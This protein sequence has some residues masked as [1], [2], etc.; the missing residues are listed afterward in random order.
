MLTA[1]KNKE[2]LKQQAFL[3]GEWCDALSGETTDVLDPASQQIIGSVPSLSPAEVQKA[4]DAAAVAFKDWSARP[5]GERA[6][7][8]KKWHRLIE[9]NKEDLAQILTMEQGKPV[10]EARVEVQASAALIE[11]FSEEAR[12][13]YG[14]IIPSPANGRQTLVTKQPVGVCAA[15]TPWNFPSSMLARKVAP[16]LA[17]GCAIVVKPSEYT[18][19]SALALAALAEQAGLPSGLFNVATGDARMIGEVI[20]ASS[21]VRKVSFTGSTRIGKLLIAQAADTVKRVSME[22]GGNAP[23][24]VFDDA[25]LDLAIDGVLASKFRNAGQTCI[26]A[27]RVLVQDGIFDRFIE[28]LTAR[29]A[30]MKVGLGLDEDT[31]IGPMIHAEA[32]NSMDDIINSAVADG[33]R[34]VA[35]GKH[36]PMGENFFEP[37]I[38]VDVRQDMAIARDEVFGPITPVIRFNEEAEA[39]A[40]A[41]DT[42][43]GLASYMYTQGLARAWRVSDALEFGMVGI[44]EAGISNEVAPFGGMKESGFGREGSKYGIDEYIDVKYRCMGG[45]L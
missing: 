18:P 3:A 9:E 13:V 6:K 28:K 33:A 44:N 45:L 40:I 7:V 4:I 16:A 10:S 26:C 43:Y 12:R 32:A 39:I 34:I 21:V 19:F 1:L 23:F 36:H 14:D 8:L 35:G 5:A 17:A 20:M 2:L 27:N 29:V 42:P 38:L 24:I 25:D 41:N 37:T 30:G 11:W 31:L 15:I 22:L